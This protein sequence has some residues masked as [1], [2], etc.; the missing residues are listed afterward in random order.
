MPADHS[1]EDGRRPRALS[2]NVL[3]AAGGDCGYGLP[4]FIKFALQSRGKCGSII[5]EGTPTNGYPPCFRKLLRLAW[6]A[7]GRSNFFCLSAEKRN[8]FFL[9]RSTRSMT[10]WMIR[11]IS[12]QNASRLSNVMTIPIPPF[13]F[14]SCKGKKAGECRPPWCFAQRIA[15]SYDCRWQSYL[16]VQ[17][18]PFRALRPE[19]W[20]HNPREKAT[21]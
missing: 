5:T 3:A 7:L 1:H 8:H 21:F 18:C 4:F 13:A 19:I 17:W 12:V 15:T 16:N 11:I 14:F 2:G 9:F 10:R 20:Y 6:K